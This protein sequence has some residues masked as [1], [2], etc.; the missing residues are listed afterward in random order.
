MKCACCGGIF[1]SGGI[2]SSIDGQWYIFCSSLC[3]TDFYRQR[4][5]ANAGRIEKELEDRW[6]AREGY[7]PI[8]TA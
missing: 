4:L 5:L 6:R 3:M 8:R 7:F 2:G 1:A